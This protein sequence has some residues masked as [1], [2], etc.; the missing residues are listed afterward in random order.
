MKRV[1]LVIG[2]RD[3]YF[4][5]YFFLIIFVCL[6]VVV[7][8]FFNYYFFAP[9]FDGIEFWPKRQRWRRATV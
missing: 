9:M 5:I 1:F 3:F 4:L 2:F 6:F 8:V 7:V